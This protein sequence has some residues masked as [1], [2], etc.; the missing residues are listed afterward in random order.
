MRGM[1]LEYLERDGENPQAYK[2]TVLGEGLGTL[3]THLKR[4]YEDRNVDRTNVCHVSFPR[5]CDV[6]MNFVLPSH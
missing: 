3:R 2:P 4:V 1:S 6:K 5:F